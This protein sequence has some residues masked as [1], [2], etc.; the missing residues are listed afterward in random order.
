MINFVIEFLQRNLIIV[1]AILSFAIL[2]SLSFKKIRRIMYGGIATGITTLGFVIL[3]RFGLGFNAFYDIFVKIA[4]SVIKV[5]E[6]IQE[7]MIENRMVLQIVSLESDYLNDQLYVYDTF[8]VYYAKC[9][10]TQ[11]YDYFFEIKD[12]LFKNLAIIRENFIK[13]INL[14]KY[15]FAYRL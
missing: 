8:A 11:I 5:I 12:K 6:G 1:V 3:H 10:L 13:K 14:S 4:T 7:T 15:T 9:F 2:F